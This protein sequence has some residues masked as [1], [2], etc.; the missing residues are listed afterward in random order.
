MLAEAGG[1]RSELPRALTE[2]FHSA[3]TAGAGFAILGVVLGLLLIKGKPREERVDGEPLTD[4][5]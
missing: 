5:A 2:G 4:A 1:A 3:F